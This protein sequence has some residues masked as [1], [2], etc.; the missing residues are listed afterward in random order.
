M[1][2]EQR[3]KI[4]NNLEE[5]IPE[6]ELKYEIKKHWFMMPY[7]LTR[8]LMTKTGERARNWFTGGDS[9]EKRK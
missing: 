2:E 6:L 4:K 9:D 1:S 7:Y 5:T 8:Q 3:A